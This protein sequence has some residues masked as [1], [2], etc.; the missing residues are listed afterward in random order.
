VSKFQTTR[1]SLI[2]AARDSPAQAR[3]ALEQLCRAYRPPVLA[4]VRHSGYAQADAEDLTQAFFLRFLERGWY[5]DADPGRGRFRTLVL[6]SLRNFLHD[7]HAQAAALKRGAGKQADADILDRIASG[8]SPEEAFTRAW[9]GTVLARAMQHLEREW[10]RAGKRAQF[11][12]LAPL[13]VEHADASELRGI[14]AATGVR[15]NTIA[16]QAH[17]MRQRLRQLVR[18]ELLQT[19]GSGEALEQELAELREA[20]ET[21]SAPASATANP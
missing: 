17:R 21:S 9:L 11:E 14:A 6:V 12:Q 8:E 20:L 2:V 18:L 15:S 13:L 19:V 4:F 7:Q 10:V 3:S 1:W 16:V 5:A